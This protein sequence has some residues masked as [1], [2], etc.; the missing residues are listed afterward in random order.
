MYLVSLFDADE[1]R[2]F[3]FECDFGGF[4]SLV[5]R[6]DF[7]VVVFRQLPDEALLM[8]GSLNAARHRQQKNQKRQQQRHQLRHGS[9]H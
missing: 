8:L 5:D 9:R 2:H 6:P 3:C 1:L 7:R 4:V